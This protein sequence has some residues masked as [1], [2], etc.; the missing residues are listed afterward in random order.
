MIGSLIDRALDNRFVVGLNT[1]LLIAVGLWATINLPI[2]AVPDV[3]NVQVQILTTSPALGP[4]EVEQFI[5]F[6][7]E[8]A[9][10]GI[11]RIEEVR[12]VSQFPGARLMVIRVV[13]SP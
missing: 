8:S 13:P 9:L 7:V 6:P 3:T 12:S 1:L 2:D 10:S 4:L 5:T 11:P